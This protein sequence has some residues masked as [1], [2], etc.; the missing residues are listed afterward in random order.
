[1]NDEYYVGLDLGTGSLGWAVTDSAYNLVRRHGKTLWG[2]RLFESANTAEERRLYR[3]TRRRIA[4]QKWRVQLLQ[5]IFAEEITKVDPG[6][7]QRMK[8][9]RYVPEDKKTFKEIRRNFHMHFL[10][11]LL[12]QIKIIMESF[13]PFII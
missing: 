8:E 6:F 11:M 13:R 9:S 4:R 10:W 7:Y 12:L 1:M 5:E 3:T 2:V